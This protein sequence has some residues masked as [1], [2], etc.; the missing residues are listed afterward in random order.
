M[1]RSS[2]P[3]G[4]RPSASL[5]T[6]IAGHSRDNSSIT[7]Q[8]SQR[9]AVVRAVSHE[10]MA[11]YMVP[12]A[13]DEA[14]D[15]RPVVDPQPTPRGLPPGYFQRLPAPDTLGP[16][17]VHFPSV[18][19][20]DRCDAPEATS[21]ALGYRADNALRQTFFRFRKLRSVA[22]AVAGLTEHPAPAAFRNGEGLLQVLHRLPSSWRAGLFPETVSRSM[23][24]SKDR[25]AASL[26]RRPFSCS[27]SFNRRAYSVR[28][29][30]YSL[31]QRRVLRSGQGGSRFAH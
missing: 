29:P 14:G 3:A 30:P 5:P 24:L 10:A 20:Q 11:P 19:R 8:Q 6:R 27:R 7:R 25:P 21:A 18:P 23:A 17:V 2:T 12:G 28:R 4:R 26:F 22:M 16:L 13:G 15:T 9:P 31:S 1:A